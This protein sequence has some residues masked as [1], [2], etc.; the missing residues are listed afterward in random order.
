MIQHRKGLLVTLAVIAVAVASIWYATRPKPVAVVVTAVERGTVEQTVANTRAGTVKA[1]RRAKLSPGIGG[2]ISLLN[3]KEGEGTLNY[4][5]ND[6]VLVNDIETTVKN[7]KQGSVMLNE[8]LEA[9]RQHVLFRGYFKKLEKQE[10]KK[11]K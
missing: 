9:M 2:Q 5:V 10:K 7:V 1:C 11:S 3:I 6:T 4:L 8:N